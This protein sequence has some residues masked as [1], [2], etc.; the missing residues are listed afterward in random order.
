MRKMT[1][2][3][4][5]YLAL[6]RDIPTDAVLLFRVG[7]NYCTFEELEEN[8]ISIPVGKIGEAIDVLVSG[9][10][11]V[12]VADYA[13]DRRP[14]LATRREVTRIFSPKEK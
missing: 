9:G 8:E 13:E 6:K 10:Y 2:N 14:G 4:R 11:T 12:A 5:I 7:K 1:P 3:Y